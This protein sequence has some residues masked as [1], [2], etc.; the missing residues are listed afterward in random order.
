MIYPDLYAHLTPLCACRSV[1]PEQSPCLSDSPRVTIRK[2][3]GIRS[4][5][6]KVNHYPPI[7]PNA[8]RTKRVE[9]SHRPPPLRGRPGGGAPAK[10]RATWHRVR[11]FRKASGMGH[12]RRRGHPPPAPPGGRRARSA[13]A[14]YVALSC[15]PAPHGTRCAVGLTAPAC[16]STPPAA[17]AG[18]GSSHRGGGVGRGS[19]R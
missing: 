12:A 5:W 17:S 16:R 8:Y 1:I 19:G 13:T 3:F 2:M 10:V 15:E 14:R 18:P 4:G 7:V 9:V 11:S 6:F